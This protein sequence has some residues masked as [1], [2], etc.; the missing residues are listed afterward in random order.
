MTDPQARTWLRLEIPKRFPGEAS[1]ALLFQIRQ[2]PILDEKK[3]A[4]GAGWGVATYCWAWRAAAA[5]KRCRS[6]AL[7]N[8]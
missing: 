5:L 2:R 3:S 1:W 8:G 4:A 6:A 7:A